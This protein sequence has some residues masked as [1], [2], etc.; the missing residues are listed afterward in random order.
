LVV[1]IVDH[2]RGTIGQAEGDYQA[3]AG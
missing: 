1:E 3:T 2:R